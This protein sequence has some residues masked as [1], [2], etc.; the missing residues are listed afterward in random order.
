MSLYSER[1]HNHLCLAHAAVPPIHDKTCLMNTPEEALSHH[2]NPN[3]QSQSQSQ[4]QVTS[5]RLRPCALLIEL[6]E[7]KAYEARRGRADPTLLWRPRSPAPHPA[8]LLRFPK[9]GRPKRQDAV[10]RLTVLYHPAPDDCAAGTRHRRKGYCQN[11]R[12]RRSL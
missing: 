2:L 7:I 12:R 1:T 5:S 9:R 4:S 3:S 10:R 11:S 8:C 6:H